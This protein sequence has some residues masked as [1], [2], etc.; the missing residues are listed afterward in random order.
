MRE[1]NDVLFLVDNLAVG[2]D[3]NSSFYSK[4]PVVLDEK[5][6][7]FDYARSLYIARIQERLEKAETNDEI[8][9][10]LIKL[11]EILQRMYIE[12][13]LSSTTTYGQ[14]IL[15]YA[16]VNRFNAEKN[17]YKLLDKEY[18][19]GEDGTWSICAEKEVRVEKELLYPYMGLYNP[20]RGVFCIQA[21]KSVED[22]RGKPTGKNCMSWGAEQLIKIGRASCRERV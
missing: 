4:F 14:K 12:G 20:E 13:S 21:I 15:K 18:C 7:Y 22:T 17:R 2:A 1:E 5:E 6:T 11:P 19:L 10:N 16:L 3:Y 9:K 8:A